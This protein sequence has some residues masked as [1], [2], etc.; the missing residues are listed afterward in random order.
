MGL[1]LASSRPLS[2]AVGGGLAPSTAAATGIGGRP[3]QPGTH[4][5][6]LASTYQQHAHQ[7]TAS[8]GGAAALPGLGML[9]APGSGGGAG[10]AALPQQARSMS[11]PIPSG[12]AGLFGG[13]WSLDALDQVRSSGAGA[14]ARNG[15]LQ[16]VGGGLLDA[17]NMQENEKLMGL[18]PSDLLH[19]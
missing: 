1:D 13:L 17:A 15:S 8:S 3:L 4:H 16:Q 19:S 12:A 14:A 10:A 9:G 7:R 5:A 6:M 18:L 11:T 2:P